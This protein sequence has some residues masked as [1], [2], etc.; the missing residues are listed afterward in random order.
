[1]D[2][3]EPTDPKPC[4]EVRDLVHRYGEREA[5]AGI[6]LAVRRGEVFGFLGPNGSGK[7]TLFR[8]LSTLMAPSGG[9]ATVLGADVARDPDTVRAGIGVAFQSPSLDPKLSCLENL[10]HRG[11]LYGLSGGALADRAH[12]L[13]DRFNLGDRAGER[14]EKLSGGQRRRVELAAAL[15]HGPSVLLLDEP[16]TGLDPGARR[17]LG[18]DLRSLR[19]QDGT[20]IA[21]TTHLMEEADRCDRLVILDRGRIVAEGTPDRLCRDIGGDVIDLTSPDPRALGER[22]AREHG[23]EPRIVDGRLRIEHPDAPSLLRE[24]LPGFGGDGIESIRIGKPTLADVFLARTGRTFAQAEEV[25]SRAGAKK[26]GHEER[27]S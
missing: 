17:E 10:R 5:L 25:P 24:L 15:L 12:S 1:M 7:S 9:E 18:D 8:I 22:L 21:L 6:S 2:D 13:L 14:V 11:H 4:I 27:A 20:T 16:S 26:R 19:E 23:V 3:P